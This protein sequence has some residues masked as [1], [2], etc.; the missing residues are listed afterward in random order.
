MKKIPYRFLIIAVAALAAAVTLMPV[1]IGDSPEAEGKHLIV[2]ERID[3]SEIFFQNQPYRFN[4]KTQWSGLAKENLH[5]GV[6]LLV[7]LDET[8]VGRH[9]TLKTV[10]QAPTDE[11]EL[12]GTIG[13]LLRSDEGVVGFTI[14]NLSILLPERHDGHEAEGGHGEPAIGQGVRV[15]ATPESGSTILRALEAPEVIR[16]HDLLHAIT[17]LMLQLAVILLVAKVGGEIFERFLH[18]PGVLG[19]LIGGILISPY[20][21]GGLFNIPGVGQLFQTVSLATVLKASP[22]QPD[23][24]VSPELWAVAQM[25]AIVLL[26]MAGL[27]TDLRQF[28]RYAGPAT[29]IAIGGVVAPFFLGALATFWFIPGIESIWDPTALFMGAVMVATS[30]GITARVLSD[31]NRLDTSEGVT[32]L[33]GAVIDDVLGILVLAI[34]NAIAIV[35][36]AGGT[37]DVNTIIGIALKAVLFWLGLTG[38]GILLSKQIEKGLRWFKSKGATFGLGLALAFACAATAELFGLAMIIGAYS[39]GL[40]MSDTKI[41]HFL[42]EQ[43]K[44]VYNFVVP[45]FFVVMGM[46]VDFNQM[47][48]LLWPYGVVIS[49]FAIISKVFGCGIPALFVGFNMRGAYRVGV[50]MLPRGEVALIIAGVGIANGIIAT[51]MFGVAILLTLVTTLLA[52]PALVPAF[53]TG[54]MG[55]R[56]EVKEGVVSVAPEPFLVLNTTSRT[57]RGLVRDVLLAE[58][59]EVGFKKVLSDAASGIYEVQKNNRPVVIRILDE[60]FK[61]SIDAPEDNHEEIRGVLRKIADDMMDYRNKLMA[62]VG[63]EPQEA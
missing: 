14:N 22:L 45:V 62:Q 51:D 30:V 23:F 48:P 25:A 9:H 47:L 16:H 56:A 19:E 58:L 12:T 53:K 18:Q 61:I 27:E 1:V 46:M 28:L 21:F 35:E 7:S 50:G 10:E 59:G 36:L 34:V 3:D 39:I 37:L 4:E 41:S 57:H 8:G 11:L 15:K 40:A 49:F 29:V 33:A 38:I 2:V 13:S 20:A 44:S 42:E 43:L 17:I 54:G 55:T 63:P 6:W 31:I 60:D 26:F 52:P 32:I 24:A 5:P